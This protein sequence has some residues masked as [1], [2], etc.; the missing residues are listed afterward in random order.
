MKVDQS[1]FNTY[2][3]LKGQIGQEN[4]IE[5]ATDSEFNKDQGFSKFFATSE[6]EILK[7]KMENKNSKIDTL[8]PPALQKYG[9]NPFKYLNI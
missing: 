7:K 9:N 2:E 8:R 3:S 6:N 1:A 5:Q 4:K